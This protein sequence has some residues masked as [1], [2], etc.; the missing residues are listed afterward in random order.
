M[1]FAFDSN[2]ELVKVHVCI[3]DK[4]IKD[5]TVITDAQQYDAVPITEHTAPQIELITTVESSS[6][7]DAAD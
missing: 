1:E 2:G 6:G 4:I 3:H 7:I 5:H